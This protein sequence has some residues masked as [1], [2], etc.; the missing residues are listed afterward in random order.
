MSALRPHL[1][2]VRLE[3]GDVINETHD[4]VRKVY[5]PHAGI[6]SCVVELIGGGAIETGMIGKDGQFGAA[7][8]LDHKV[9]LNLV[10][11]QI[12]CEA[13]VVNADQFE[14]LRW[15]IRCFG[16]R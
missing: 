10:N 6:I 8:A 12:A 13:S 3:Q 9:S 5:F 14:C 4:T 2:V 16:S 15:S 7:A 11:V 1:A